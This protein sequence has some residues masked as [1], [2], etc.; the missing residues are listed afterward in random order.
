MKYYT[1]YMDRQEISPA[2]HE[3]LLNLEAPKRRSRPVWVRY[4]AL[5]AC[6]ALVIGAGVWRLALDRAPAEDLKSAAQ[7][8]PDYE[9]KPGEK[10]VVGPEDL[11]PDPYAAVK[12]ELEQGRE[13]F[14][15]PY[16]EYGP[17]TEESRAS[18]KVSMDYAAPEGST[19][20]E[21][22]RDDVITLAGGEETLDT[23]L[24]WDGFEFTGTV[25]FDRDGKVW[26][27]YLGG[28][29]DDFFFELEL[30]PDALPL[31][32]VIIEPHAV[33]QVWGVEITARRAGI[34]GE[35]PN[36]EVWM[37]ESR[38]VEFIANGAGCRFTLYGLEGQGAAVE[39]MVS[40]FVRQS[41]LEGLYL[42]NVL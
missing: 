39:E 35:G 8:A 13:Y 19:S 12:D 2:V 42:Q 14:M 20:R 21:L 10:D 38:E 41:I 23:E 36:R 9:P 16:I 26:Q 3:K 24:N 27:M 31:T 25:I 40:R 5:A 22:T 33:T 4:G 11:P 34:H 32:C 37:P 30:A 1:S 17:V 29:R 7:F 28:K 6:A 15:L 18:S